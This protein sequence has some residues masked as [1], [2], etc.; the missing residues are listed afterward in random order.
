MQEERLR[1]LKMIEDGKLTVEEAL[2]L[3]EGLD[4][5][6]KAANEKQ[7]DLFPD[8]STVKFEEA[9]KEDPLNYKFQSAKDKIIDFVDQAYK[10]IKDFDLDFNF[11]KSIDISHIFEQADVDLKEIDIDLA[12][13]MV[14]VLPW[15]QNNVRIE[16][17]AKIY[18]VETQDEARRKF[19]NE[20]V[21]MI[22]SQRLRFSTQQKWMKI[23][24]VIYI[25]QTEYENIKIRMF[26]GSIES[27]HLTAENYKA[28]TANGKITLS[29]IKGSYAEAE[30]S[31]GQILIQ[32]SFVGQLEA[33]TLNG[34]ITLD[35]EYRKVDLQS[36]NGDIFCAFT[37]GV[38]EFI[39]A[40]AAT[41]GIELQIPNQTAAVEGELKTNLGGFNVNLE[42]I[43]VVEEKSDV[44]QKVMRFKSL[45][46]PEQALRIL[47]ETKTGSIQVKKAKSEV[48]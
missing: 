23:E 40:K 34:A 47:A 15:E 25:P 18:R 45:N 48:F 11:G 29:D 19:L 9:K 5:S 35:G 3:L 44:I 22:D 6:N 21:F 36:F 28:K 27:E 43:Q 20:V 12:N 26:N 17:Q 16:C 38:C 39:D 37:G 33:E 31:N 14:K 2:L 24:A 8:L 7:N 1:I 4:Q 10:K 32:R 46:N 42:G 41:G 13:G 30:T